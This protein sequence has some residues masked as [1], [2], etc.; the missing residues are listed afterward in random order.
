[1]KLFYIVNLL[2]Y[3]S[4]FWIRLGSA[5]SRRR[6]CASG[7]FRDELGPASLLIRGSKD[8]VG[9]AHA[10]PELYFVAAYSDRHLR[11]ERPQLSFGDV[12]EAVV[13]NRPEDEPAA[14]VFWPAAEVHDRALAMSARPRTTQAQVAGEDTEPKE[15]SKPRPW[16]SVVLVGA[17]APQLGQRRLEAKDSRPIS[18]FLQQVVEARLRRRE[19]LSYLARGKKVLSIELCYGVASSA[20]HPE[21][22]SYPGTKYRTSWE[23]VVE[24]AS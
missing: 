12:R 11:R 8:T 14:V 5:C 3:F 16:V 21:S 10:F 6:A 1:M 23:G 2:Q 22:S 20:S 15:G 9:L 19:L 7:L 17:A 13:R 18:E 24:N 4:G